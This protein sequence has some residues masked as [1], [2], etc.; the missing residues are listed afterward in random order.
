MPEQLWER[1]NLRVSSL[2]K[3]HGLVYL[4]AL[5]SCVQQAEDKLRRVFD[6]VWR[7]Q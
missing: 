7:Q 4:T 2:T 3:R 5:T 1:E 6:S